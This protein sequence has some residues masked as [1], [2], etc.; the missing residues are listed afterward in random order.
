MLETRVHLRKS[1]ALGIMSEE[2]HDMRTIP[3]PIRRL[4]PL[5]GMGLMVA[6]LFGCLTLPGVSAPGGEPFAYQNDRGLQSRYGY[7]HP[8]E[9]QDYWGQRDPWGYRHDRPS[10]KPRYGLPD[11]YT[12]HKGK[13]CEL[14]CE[15]I[16]GTRE[17]NCREY[18]C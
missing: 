2:A 13:K 9:Q 12:I 3:P 18:R 16:R 14:R 7:Q 11:R 15:R 4:L 10:R 1:P 6:G 5:V 17:Y 8:W